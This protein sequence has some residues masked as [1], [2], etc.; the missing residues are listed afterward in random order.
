MSPQHH[1]PQAKHPQVYRTI[2]YAGAGEAGVCPRDEIAAMMISAFVAPALD[3]VPLILASLDP[4]LVVEASRG[5][6]ALHSAA[7]LVL[8]HCAA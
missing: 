2:V 8:V 4:A 6:V 5:P 3:L 7:A 1:H